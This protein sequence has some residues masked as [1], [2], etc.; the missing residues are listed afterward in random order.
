[1][2]SQPGPK[3]REARRAE[4]KDGSR[5]SRARYQHPGGECL[6]GRCF[7]IIHPVTDDNLRETDRVRGKC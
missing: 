6:S 2:R 3:T 4:Y 7:G 5:S 1:M